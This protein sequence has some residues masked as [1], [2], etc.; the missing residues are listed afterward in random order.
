MVKHTRQVALMELAV[1]AEERVAEVNER[2][3][4]KYEELVASCKEKGLK[5]WMMPVE[6][7]CLGSVVSPRNC[8]GA[9]EGE[10]E[11]LGGGSGGG[12]KSITVD[13][14]KEDGKAGYK[15][16]FTRKSP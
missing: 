7:G 10:K 8:G 9:G 15:W 11:C 5:T 2:K 16:M 4:E 14:E 6:V 1:P 12:I 3:R 13:L